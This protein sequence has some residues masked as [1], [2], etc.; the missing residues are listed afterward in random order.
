MDSLEAW[1]E[2]RRGEEYEPSYP[3]CFY[4]GLRC[5]GDTTETVVVYD[6]ITAEKVV[7]DVSCTE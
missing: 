1:L 7:C 5:S 2:F 3:C 6:D 4:C